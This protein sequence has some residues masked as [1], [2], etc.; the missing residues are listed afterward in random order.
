MVASCAYLLDPVLEE[1][2]HYGELFTLHHLGEAGD[3]DLSCLV[4]LVRDARLWSACV[5][6]V[7]DACLSILAV[8]PSVETVVSSE[9]ERVIAASCDHC[10]L[11][12][13]EEVYQTWSLVHIP[14]AMT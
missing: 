5:A 11:F 12:V 2:W 4:G 14:I 6:E 1:S 9:S 10:D 8:A 13:C 3:R 7:T